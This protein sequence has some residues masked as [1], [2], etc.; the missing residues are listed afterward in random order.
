[1]LTL[2]LLYFN[3]SN[4]R[5]LWI[6]CFKNIFSH[7]KKFLT[8][9]CWLYTLLN[10]LPKL[11]QNSTAGN[12]FYHFTRFDWNKKDKYTIYKKRKYSRKKV[13]FIFC[14]SYFYKFLIIKQRKYICISCCFSIWKI[15]RKVKTEIVSQKIIEL[16]I[17][18]DGF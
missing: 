10:F 13:L 6:G 15:K 3:S 9:G 11:F 17:N 14:V 7:F 18:S 16:D 8:N 1:M 4:F 12:S 2:L 5:I